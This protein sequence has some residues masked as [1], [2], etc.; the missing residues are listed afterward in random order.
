MSNFSVFL[1][2]NLCQCINTV[3]LLFIRISITTKTRPESPTAH[4][5]KMNK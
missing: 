5:V 4:E 2:F 1:D 3:V